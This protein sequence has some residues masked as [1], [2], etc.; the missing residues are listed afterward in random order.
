[1][2]A[3]GWFSCSSKDDELLS[4]WMHKLLMIRLKQHSKRATIT[5]GYA[6]GAHPFK[7]LNSVPIKKAD[8]L[9]NKLSG[10]TDKHKITFVQKKVDMNWAI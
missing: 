8:R 4:R 6:R 3:L 5:G 9:S 7:R 10:L 2:N 1:V